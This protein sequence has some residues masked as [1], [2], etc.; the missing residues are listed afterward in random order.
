MM[1]SA[2]LWERFA[3]WIISTS[4][5]PGIA[6]ALHGLLHQAVCQSHNLALNECKIMLL[7]KA[8]I[9]NKRVRYNELINFYFNEIITLKI[10]QGIFL[11]AGRTDLIK[12]I[13][14]YP[15]S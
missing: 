11:S 4:V 5:P 10:R 12:V 13:Q 15:L 8:S 9:R 6:A 3:S 14:N 2:Q 7:P 1:Q